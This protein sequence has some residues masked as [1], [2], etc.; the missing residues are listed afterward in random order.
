MHSGAE[1]LFSFLLIFPGLDPEPDGPAVAEFVTS[2]F[3]GANFGARPG[4]G[5]VDV[6]CEFVVL[7]GGGTGW[8]GCP[9]INDKC[10]R[11]YKISSIAWIASHFD[12]GS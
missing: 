11:L 12:G 6:I 9:A 5:R 8:R 7:G 2:L 4:R 1:L 10:P 3:E